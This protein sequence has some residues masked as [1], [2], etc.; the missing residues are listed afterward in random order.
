MGVGE[1]IKE[2]IYV[3]LLMIQKNMWVILRIFIGFSSNVLVGKL[4]HFFGIGF[5][6][7]LV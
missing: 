7:Q 4:F 3:E 2:R 5:L 6:V 1:R